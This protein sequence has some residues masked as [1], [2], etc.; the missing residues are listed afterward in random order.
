M[1][2]LD[3]DCKPRTARTMRVT[4]GMLSRGGIFGEGMDACSN[5]KAN[6]EKGT[7]HSKSD[8]Y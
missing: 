4:G 5:N 1:M 8:M 6:S 3:K 2:I 7:E